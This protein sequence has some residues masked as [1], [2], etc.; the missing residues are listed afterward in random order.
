MSDTRLVGGI[1]QAKMDPVLVSDQRGITAQDQALLLDFDELRQF[2]HVPVGQVLALV[3]RG[4][5][6]F[7][8]GHGLRSDLPLQRIQIAP[9]G[10]QFAVGVD[11][12]F[13]LFGFVRRLFGAAG[14][15]IDF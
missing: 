8:A 12:H 15:Q 4:R 14:G 1:E 6:T 13:D 11:D 9:A 2:A 5:Q 3:L 10:E 7:E